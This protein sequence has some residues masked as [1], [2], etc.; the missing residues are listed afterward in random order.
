[1]I[2]TIK[3]PK[4][5]LAIETSCDETAAAVVKNGTEVLSNV[6]ASQIEKHKLTGGVVPEIAAR[7]HI[8]ILPFVYKEALEKAGV[9]AEELDLI[10][11]TEKP[12]LLSSLM[13]G[14]QT[15][16]TLAYIHNKPYRDIDHIEGH[17]F[18]N[19]LKRNPEE[20]S[21]PIVTLTVSGGH[22]NLYLLKSPTDIQLLGETQDDAAG[23]AFDKVAKMLGLAYPGGPSVAK[24]AL[25]GKENV[26][27][28]PQ[29]KLKNVFD[30]S[31]SGLKTSVLYLIQKLT[32]HGEK[33]LSE[34]EISDIAKNFELT[35]AK[36]L[37]EKLLKAAQQ[38]GAQEI[39]LAGG[40]SANLTLRNY[41]NE[42][43]PE[44]L[45]FRYPEEFSFC[46][47]NAAMIAA[48]AYA[49]LNRCH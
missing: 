45:K 9:R 8:K 14:I 22:N 32:K 23:E 33:N 5:I 40:V 37:T 43:K 27:K 2:N 11:A 34:Q 38:F 42:Q 4:L 20:F 1:M 25:N 30:F 12:G 13:M 10:V 41:I 29:P 48:A 39:H 6:I 35:V 3:S 28:F 44:N 47:D 18:S 31:F 15:A 49:K 19:W 17:I 26:Y 7:E 46:T 36:N 16:R 24:A 21:Y